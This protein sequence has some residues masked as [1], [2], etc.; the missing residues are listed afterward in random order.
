MLARRGYGAG[1]A[2]QAIREVG[3]DDGATEDLGSTAE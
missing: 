2:M 1:V 3:D